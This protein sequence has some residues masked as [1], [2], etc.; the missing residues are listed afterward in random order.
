MLP[1]FLPTLSAFYNEKFLRGQFHQASQIKKGIASPVEQDPDFYEMPLIAEDSPF[2]RMVDTLWDAPYWVASDDHSLLRHLP[3]ILS[4]PLLPDPNNG[5]PYQPQRLQTLTA[6]EDDE[7]FGDIFQF[8]E[9]L[10]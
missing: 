8:F 3:A 4:A 10:V 9:D 2:P 1:C 7:F 5:R 6:A